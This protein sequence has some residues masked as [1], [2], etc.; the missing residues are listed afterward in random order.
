MNNSIKLSVILLSFM[1]FYLHSDN[2]PLYGDPSKQLAI[3][4]QEQYP[5]NA[6]LSN[7]TVTFVIPKYD[8]EMFLLLH[9]AETEYYQSLDLSHQHELKTTLLQIAHNPR[10]ELYLLPKAAIESYISELKKLET[11]KEGLTNKSAVNYNYS[12]EESIELSKQTQDLR[13]KSQI[14]AYLYPEKLEN[15]DRFT[16]P[17][18]KP[19]PIVSTPAPTPTTSTRMIPESNERI[20]RLR[21]PE[22]E[23][24]IGVRF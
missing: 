12:K 19:T 21:I 6:K 23:I 7:K 15:D 1:T 4:E 11:G 2:L 8:Q 14:I 9:Y 13:N 22:Q 20:L 24:Q 5:S 18:Y 10:V 17:N 3:L 16:L